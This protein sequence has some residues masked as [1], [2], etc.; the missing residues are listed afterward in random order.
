LSLNQ[1]YYIDM[2]NY[3]INNYDYRF[4][5]IDYTI[6]YLNNNTNNSKL[7]YSDVTLYYYECD[8]V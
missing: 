3:R 1:Y 5:Q 8:V 4:K 6:K 7:V 2:T